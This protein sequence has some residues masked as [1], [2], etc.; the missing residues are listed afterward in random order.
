V[1]WRSSCFQE[2]GFFDEDLAYEDYD[3]LLRISKKYKIG[4]EDYMSAEYRIHENNFSHK[5]RSLRYLE[6]DFK[7]YAKH[8]GVS[9][10]SDAI[11]KGKMERIIIEMS[12][13]DA[14]NVK[15]LFRVY[16]NYFNGF[17]TMK[18]ALKTRLDFKKILKITR[19]LDA[20]RA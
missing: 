17:S 10:E 3:M 4:Y 19:A 5:S 11:I 12:L 15:E 6:T 14:P 13:Q 2:C 16:S 20:L 7:I 9:D 1:L 8:I 18:F